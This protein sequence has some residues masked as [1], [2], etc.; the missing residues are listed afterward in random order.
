VNDAIDCR[1]T[2]VPTA[3]P[4]AKSAA[5]S[6]NPG[7]QM[8]TSATTWSACHPDRSLSLPRDLVVMAEYSAF[9]HE[10]CLYEL[11]CEPK[12]LRRSK[13]GTT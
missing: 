9:L 6:T 13:K 3:P 2:A 11:A 12:W 1:G 7:F 5:E 4:T 8:L 10:R